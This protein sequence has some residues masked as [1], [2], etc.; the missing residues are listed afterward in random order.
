MEKLVSICIP[1]YNRP[2]FLNESIT[3]CI[4]QN[5]SN[6][7]ILIGDDSDNDITRLMVD[8]FFQMT[9]IKYFKNEIGKGEAENINYLIDRAA[10]EYI[11]VL[12]DDDMLVESSIQEMVTT[13]NTDINISAVFGLQYII[14]MNSRIDFH[15]SETNNKNYYR[16]EKYVGEQKNPLWS[17]V[18]QQFPNNGFLIRADIIKKVK[19]DSSPSIKYTCDFDLGIRIAEKSQKF[20]LLP[21]YTSKYRITDSSLSKNSSIYLNSLNVLSRVKTDDKKIKKLL[22]DKKISFLIMIIRELL[23]NHKIK[24]ARF[25]FLKNIK[26]LSIKHCILLPFCYFPF[27]IFFRFFMKI[28]SKF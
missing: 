7:E 3:S 20:F 6:L 24:E 26:I 25:Y 11:I 27:D 12:H 21:K 15:K 4:N 16:S 13:I 14:D 8:K 1:T 17:A 10:G 18:A 2:N 22:N 19:Y 5:Y 28:K 23:K 9:N